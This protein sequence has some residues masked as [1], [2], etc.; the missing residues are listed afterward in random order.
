MTKRR[1]VSLARVTN[2]RSDQDEPTVAEGSRSRCPAFEYEG[3]RFRTRRQGFAGR[4]RSVLPRRR[5][6]VLPRNLAAPDLLPC[7]FVDPHR[8][9]GKVLRLR[10]GLCSGGLG[11]VTQEGFTSSVGCPTLIECL[12]AELPPIHAVGRGDVSRMAGPEEP[13]LV[14][15]ESIGFPLAEASHERGS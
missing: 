13:E 9:Q 11:S 10:N 3:I 7:D 14:A 15:H 4:S 8:D 12:V 1:R 5:H 2:P 6:C